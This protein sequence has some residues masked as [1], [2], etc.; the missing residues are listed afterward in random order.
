MTSSTIHRNRRTD[1]IIK[2]E[3]SWNGEGSYCV[4]EDS[5]LDTCQRQMMYC[6]L[7]H[8]GLRGKLIFLSSAYRQCSSGP[9]GHR[10]KMTAHLRCVQGL[11]LRGALSSLHHSSAWHAG[12]TSVLP[13]LGGSRKWAWCRTYL[14]LI[15]W[16]I[17][18]MACCVAHALMF[19][20]LREHGLM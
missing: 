9:T 11:G 13:L 12:T 6:S 17:A 20:S 14:P 1:Q 4:T 5:G 7:R 18:S 8:D 10:V 16:G 3:I 2:M 15:K 19:G